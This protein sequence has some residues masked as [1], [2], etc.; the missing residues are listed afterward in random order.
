MQ[1]VI[2]GFLARRRVSNKRK[3]LAALAL[4]RAAVAIQCAARCMLARRLAS[5]LLQA[6]RDASRQQR[7]N[8]TQARATS[9][10][11]RRFAAPSASLS[12][13]RVFVLFHNLE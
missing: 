12:R 5:R 1:A 10:Q 4:L 3:A 7:Y 13:T 8:V 6:Q 11:H 2:R 9:L